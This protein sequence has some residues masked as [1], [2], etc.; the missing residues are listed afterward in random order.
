MSEPTLFT[1][2]GAASLE[3][4]VVQA[5]SQ[6]SATALKEIHQKRVGRRPAP[7]ILVAV[8]SREKVAVCGDVGGETKSFTTESLDRVERLCDAALQAPDRHA[9]SRFISRALTQLGS[10]LPGV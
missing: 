4:V 6:P 5:S 3:V 9:A 2:S 8:W 10:A 1:G 7:V